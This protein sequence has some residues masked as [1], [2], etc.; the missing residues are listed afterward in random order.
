MTRGDIVKLLSKA[1]SAFIIFFSVALFYVVP[2]YPDLIYL[3][4]GRTLE[5]RITEQTDSCYKVRLKVVEAKLMKD[6]VEFVEKRDLPENFFESETA[7]MSKLLGETV[8]AES[9]S[10]PA[11]AEGYSPPGS[12]AYTANFKISHE[13]GRKGD[14][15][16]SNI[17]VEILTNIPKD[18]SARVAFK[19]K[20]VVI[21]SRIV[22]IQPG[23]LCVSFGPFEK[24]FLPAVYT[25]TLEF[26]I[27]E[28]GRAEM[29]H[30]EF[31]IGSDKD[32]SEAYKRTKAEAENIIAAID[33]CSSELDRAYLKNR[34]SYDK[35]RWSGWSDKWLCDLERIG[36]RFDEVD[37]TYVIYLYP[38]MQVNMP[39]CI[40]S[41]KKVYEIY[42]I[43]VKNSIRVDKKIPDQTKLFS[44]RKT[45]TDIFYRS[46]SAIMDDVTGM[47]TSEQGLSGGILN[48]A[49]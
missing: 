26:P 6:E 33:S 42:D 36:G 2:A 21:E 44:A 22:R 13:K 14:K 40:Q 41:L 7:E 4:N 37:E 48:R 28:D 15:P 25:I 12:S 1:G 30:S 8:S 18:A 32:I 17:N 45:A 10:N 38:V 47:Q 11:G 16:V 39:I 34:G 49:D 24:M 29:T 3:K 31:K 9:V 19:L 46:F 23:K 35:K 43:Q 20:G 27:N 5:G